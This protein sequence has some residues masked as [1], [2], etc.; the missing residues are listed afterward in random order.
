MLTAGN[1]NGNSI[2]WSSSNLNTSSNPILVNVTDVYYVTLTNTFGC[3][4]KNWV[5]V[6]FDSLLMPIIPKTNMPDTIVKCS[7][8]LVNYF[9]YDSLTNP[10]GIIN[11][12][13]PGITTSWSST[14]FTG[15]YGCQQYFT[16]SG[17]FTA[18]TTGTYTVNGFF[19]RQ[20]YCGVDTFY[21]TKTFYL[22]VNPK[23]TANVVFSGGGLLCPGDTILLT[24]T[25]NSVSTP[26]A[27]L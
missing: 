6:Q 2:N 11:Q 5:Y 16:L 15:M 22:L 24:A 3:T 17:C 19:I 25:Y 21:F 26:N 8:Q 10:M 7:G 1:I 14:P 23:P 18:I 12:C 20:N 27:V 9:V 13:I 4:N